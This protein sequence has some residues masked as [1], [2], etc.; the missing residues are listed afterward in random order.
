MV[1]FGMW[2]LEARQPTLLACLWQRLA[3]TD[4]CSQTIDQQRLGVRQGKPDRLCNLRAT[5][6]PQEAQSKS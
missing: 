3:I 2:D 5:H 4:Q 1:T 6:A